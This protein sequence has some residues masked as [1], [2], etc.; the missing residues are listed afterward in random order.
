[1]TVGTQA[2][3][4]ETQVAMNTVTAIATIPMPSSTANNMSTAADER[5][6]S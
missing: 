5:F 3:P 4:T 6:G 1:M 2:D